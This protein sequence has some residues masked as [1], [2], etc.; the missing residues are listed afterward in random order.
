MKPPKNYEIPHEIPHEI[1]IFQVC[2]QRWVSL[3]PQKSKHFFDQR[4]WRCSTCDW[5]LWILKSCRKYL[6]PLLRH[7]NCYSDL[8]WV[9]YTCVYIYIIYIY[10]SLLYRIL[11]YFR[12][13]PSTTNFKPSR[14][15]HGPSCLLNTGI[16]WALMFANVCGVWNTCSKCEQ[17]ECQRFFLGWKNICWI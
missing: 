1:R 16:S 11:H 8:F 13:L 6:H 5:S 14:A 17:E 9:M 12:T 3:D 15:H 4:T 10:T 7:N 2:S